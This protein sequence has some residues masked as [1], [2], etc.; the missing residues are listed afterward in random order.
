MIKKGKLRGKYRYLQKG[1]REHSTATKEALDC[2]QR[3]SN[4]GLPLFSGLLKNETS[5]GSSTSLQ[6]I[7]SER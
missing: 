1:V 4:K 6:F 7:I 2:F 5:G 3:T